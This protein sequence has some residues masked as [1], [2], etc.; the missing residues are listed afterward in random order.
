MTFS[1]H[2]GIVRVYVCY[3]EGCGNYYGSST[4]GKLEEQENIGATGSGT[5]GK[6]TSR[7]D[8]CPNCGAPRQE[9]LA[10]L[11]PP[12]EVREV[13]KMVRDYIENHGPRPMPIGPGQTPYKP[14][15]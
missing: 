4:M 10:R 9:R 12:E 15:K 5:P 3:T 11:I 13:T 7:R 6:V 1:H 8:K 14:P 2:D